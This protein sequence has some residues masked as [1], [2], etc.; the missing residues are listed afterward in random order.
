MR[1]VSRVR[2]GTE[3]RGAVVV[4]VAIVATALVAMAALVVD[5]GALLDEQRQLQNG[6]DAAALGVAHSCALGSCDATLANGLADSNANDR[7]AAVD[8]VAVDSGARQVGVVT[9][10]RGPG[11]GTILPYALG[12]AAAG[13]TGKTVHARASAAWAPIGQA[14]ALRLAISQCDVSLLGFAPTSSVIR[15]HSNTS[16][17][18]AS[19]G[20]DV[21]GAFGWLVAPDKADCEITLTA[22]DKPFTDTGSS[23]PKCLGPLLDTDVLIPVFDDRSALVG[24]GSNAQYPVVGFA[25][26]HLTG[27]HFASDNSPSPPCSGSTDCIAGFFVRFVTTTTQGGGGDFGV[28]SVHLVS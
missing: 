11:G 17:C 9:S 4:L 27:Y 6:A 19:S 12:R 14:K 3:E 5:V 25:R 18:D 20:H 7:A 8:S 28:Y 13:Q 1:G 16:S 10:T 2:P 24:K 23:G 21:G 22:G 15:F 26:F